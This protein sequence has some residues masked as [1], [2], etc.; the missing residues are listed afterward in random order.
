MGYLITI[1]TPSL[2][3]AGGTMRYCLEP[4]RET[5][6]RFHC[7]PARCLYRRHCPKLNPRV[8]VDLGELRGLIYRSARG[9]CTRPRTF[10][11][12]FEM[13]AQLT[14]DPSGRQL[15]IHGGNYRVTHRGIEG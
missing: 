12:F 13:P 3:G 11:H 4:A 6:R 2:P 14:C 1:S 9:V 5:Y 10:I 8:Q 15:Y 7:V